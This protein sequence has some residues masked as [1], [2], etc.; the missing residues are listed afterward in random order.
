MG[1]KSDKNKIEENSPILMF[2]LGSVE[3]LA[4][5]KKYTKSGNIIVVYEPSFE[6]LNC[7]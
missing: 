5:L 1:A 2:G 4:A 3:Y 7:V 6:I